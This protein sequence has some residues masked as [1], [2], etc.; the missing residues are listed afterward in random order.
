MWE[1]LP[2]NPFAERATS[3]CGNKHNWPRLLVFPLHPFLK[4]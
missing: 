4:R 1:D 3:A 2:P